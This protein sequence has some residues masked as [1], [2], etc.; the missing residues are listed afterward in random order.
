LRE[1]KLVKQ[2]RT[3]FHSPL[4]AIVRVWSIAT[5][6]DDGACDDDDDGRLRSPELPRLQTLPEPKALQGT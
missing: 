4:R 1:E 3:S 6:D 2:R 5:C